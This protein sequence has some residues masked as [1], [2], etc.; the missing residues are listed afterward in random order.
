MMHKTIAVLT[1]DMSKNR[2][3]HDRIYVRNTVTRV[4]IYRP[5][6]D[7]CCCYTR[8]AKDEGPR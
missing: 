7:G 1:S 6:G 8:G 2:L 3:D 4:Y 5:R